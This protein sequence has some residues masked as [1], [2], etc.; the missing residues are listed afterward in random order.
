M[1]SY[2]ISKSKRVKLANILDPTVRRI[3]H[4]FDSP[5]LLE[6]EDTPLERS[7]FNKLP[8]GKRE[9]IIPLPFSKISF[10]TD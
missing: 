7:V 4:I 1:E 9:K 5:E 2:M 3:S 6:A 10:S 8:N